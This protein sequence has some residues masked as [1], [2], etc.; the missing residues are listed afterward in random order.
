MVVDDS[1]GEDIAETYGGIDAVFGGLNDGANESRFAAANAVTDVE[2][3]RV[4]DGTNVVALACRGGS[5]SN[6]DPLGRWRS[7]FKKGASGGKWRR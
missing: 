7:S 6:G 1:F 5:G 4:S 2:V 3:G